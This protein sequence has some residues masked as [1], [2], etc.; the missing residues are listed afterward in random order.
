MT[1]DPGAFPT[2]ATSAKRVR[3]PPLTV[4]RPPAIGHGTTYRLNMDEH[5]RWDS[6]SCASRWNRCATR[7]P[8]RS[9]RLCRSAQVGTMRTWSAAR[10]QKTFS[11]P[12]NDHDHDHAPSLIPP[13]QD[14][15]SG[16]RRRPNST[17]STQRTASCPVDTLRAAFLSS[18]PPRQGRPR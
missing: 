15:R 12:A 18:Q 9:P 4:D 10:T 13:S 1:Y 14:R 11:P 16:T 7:S 6:R 8:R 17:V 3:L 5:I 2:N